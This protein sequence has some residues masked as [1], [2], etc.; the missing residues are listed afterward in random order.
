MPASYPS[1]IRTF[2]NKIDLVDTILADHV[3]ALQDEVRS[4]EIVLGATA[5][6]GNPLTSTYDGTFSTTTEWTSLDQRINNIEAGLVNGTGTNSPYVKKAGDAIQPTA[7]TVGLVI[8]T[9]S[10]TSNI[11]EARASDN[12]LGFNINSAGIPKVGTA[13]VLYVGSSEYNTLNSTA[14][15][16]LASAEAVRFDPFLLAGM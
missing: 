14:S 3:N 12:T 5:L 10:G 7:G 2:T 9:I 11:F 8:K 16:A 4:L 13:N 15:T 6:G 1:S